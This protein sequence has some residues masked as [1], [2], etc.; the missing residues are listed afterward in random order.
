MANILSGSCALIDVCVARHFDDFDGAC[1]QSAIHNPLTATRP[2]KITVLLARPCSTVPMCPA[3]SQ[4]C[5]PYPA[6]QLTSHFLTG[7]VLAIPSCPHCRRFLCFL[8]GPLSTCCFLYHQ[9]RGRRRRKEQHLTSAIGVKKRPSPD[10]KHT[11]LAVGR[12]G[13]EALAKLVAV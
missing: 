13:G 7:D 4:Q 12:G 2:L 11:R 5:H 9:Q 6:P 1:P 8:D 10:K 3:L